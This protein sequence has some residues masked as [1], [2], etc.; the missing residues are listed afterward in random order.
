M[1]GSE[2]DQTLEWFLESIVVHL[3]A[4]NDAP[5]YQ[6]EE[7]EEEEEGD[8]DREEGEDFFWFDEWNKSCWLKTSEKDFCCSEKRLG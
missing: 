1:D 3:P 4:A 2:D 8:A 7:E 5:G 6:E